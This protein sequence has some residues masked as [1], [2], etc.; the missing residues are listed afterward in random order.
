MRRHAQRRR[1]DA[2]SVGGGGSHVNSMDAGTAQQCGGWSPLRRAHGIR[3]VG[4]KSVATRAHVPWR[5][6]DVDHADLLPTGRRATHRRPLQQHV[7][8]ACHR[9]GAGAVAPQPHVLYAH[10]PACEISPARWMKAATPRSHGSDIM[11]PQHG[12]L[13]HDACKA[14]GAACVAAMARAPGGTPATVGARV[15]PFRARLPW[16]FIFAPRLAPSTRRG[17]S[18]PRLSLLCSRVFPSVFSLS[19]G[20]Y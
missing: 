15:L 10:G 1:P 5:I 19:L 3:R 4:R 13:A 17:V 6:G 16:P 2:T 14:R 20:C 11:G 7:T 9:P 12:G 8:A 18:F